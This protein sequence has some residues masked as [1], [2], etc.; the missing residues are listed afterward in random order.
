[1]EGNKLEVHRKDVVVRC[2]QMA[3]CI[4]DLSRQ[5]GT[6]SRSCQ[7]PAAAPSYI[8]RHVA[9]TCANKQTPTLPCLPDANPTNLWTLAKHASHALRV[10]CHE[11]TRAAGKHNMRWRPLPQHTTAADQPKSS[12]PCPST[13]CRTPPHTR[14]DDTHART[15]PKTQAKAS[16]LQQT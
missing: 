6:N 1:M 11:L 15:H 10:H 12:G 13:H 16:I 3:E 7:Q 4:A 9:A 14:T 5:K 8:C 2:Q